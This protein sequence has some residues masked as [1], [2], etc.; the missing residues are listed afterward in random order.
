MSNESTC[1]PSAPIRR[2]HCQCS[3]REEAVKRRNH[4]SPPVVGRHTSA[5]DTPQCPLNKNLGMCFLFRPTQSLDQV[6]VVVTVLQK[7]KVLL[8]K[9]ASFWQG[10]KWNSSYFLPMK[11]CPQIPFRIHFSF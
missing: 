11:T 4:I 10:G 7:E 5:L 9:R 2:V 6:L 1:S 3:Q 8:N